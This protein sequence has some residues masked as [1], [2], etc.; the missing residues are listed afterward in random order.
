MLS[1]EILLTAVVTAAACALPGVF[2][3]LRRMSMMSDAVSHAVLPGIVIAYFMLQDLN[4]PRLIVAAAVTGLATVALVE[5]LQRSKLVKEDAAIGVVFPVFFSVGV[6][7]IAQYAD[8]VHLDI[9]A[10]LLGELAFVPFD[11]FM[12]GALDLGPKALWMMGGIL[13]VNLLL[14]L[15]FYKELKLAT[16]DGAL[17]ASLGFAP[18][19]LHYGLMALL[20]V[21]AVGAFEAVGSILM[22]ALVVGPAT[23]A[24]LLTDRLD[25]TIYLAVGLGI[26]GA[27]LG[28]GLARALDSSIAGAMAT[29]QGVQ[30]LAVIAFAPRTG[31]V[32]QSRRK[33][34]QATEFA[35]RLLTIHLLQH[36]HEPDAVT[37][38]RRDHL[39][40]HFNWDQAQA[41]RVVRHALQEGIVTEKGP[42]LQLT[43][44]GRQLAQRSAT[45]F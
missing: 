11:R 41:D 16:F 29:M 6:L 31:W 32:A 43:N 5:L 3:V 35:T 23:T 24:R 40:M 25:R 17:A 10:V 12:W 37:E 42:L 27:L 15:V 28:Y 1:L 7:L 13:L 45:T 30:L 8:D 22:V 18:I 26:L 2:L 21:T 34:Q 44:G 19:V 36:E 38:C 33:R 39:L 20:S 4:D 14:L 9:D